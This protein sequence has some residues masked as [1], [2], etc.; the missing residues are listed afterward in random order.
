MQGF[1]SLLGISFSIA[2]ENLKSDPSGSHTVLLSGDVPG[3][4]VWRLVAA[5]FGAAGTSLRKSPY[6]E[7]ERAHCSISSKD[8]ASKEAACS[9]GWVFFFLC[10]GALFNLKQYT[11]GV[12]WSCLSGPTAHQ[13]PSKLLSLIRTQRRKGVPTA[14]LT[15]TQPAL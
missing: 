13:P 9:Q 14:I 11:Q 1:I 2:L 12:A 4:R 7:I 6:Q 3:G 15:L 5:G 10:K 8:Q